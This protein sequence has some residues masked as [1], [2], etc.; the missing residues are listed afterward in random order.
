ME[1]L[2]KL[3]KLLTRREK[4]VGGLVTGLFCITSI[5][6]VVGLGFIFIY[7]KLILDPTELKSIPFLLWAQDFLSVNTRQ[8]LVILG[9][10]LLIVLAT[11]ALMALVCAWANFRFS[12]A[13]MASFSSDL[14]QIYLSK[15]YTYFLNH[16]STTLKQNILDEIYNAT[17]NVLIPVLYIVSE[18]LALSCIVLL[19]LFLHPIETLIMFAF[20][21]LLFGGYLLAVKKRLDVLGA[22]KNMTNHARHRLVGDAFSTIKEVILWDAK[23]H[24]LDKFRHSLKGYSYAMAWSHI[25]LQ[26]PRYLIEAVGFCL[27]VGLMMYQLLHSQDP[28]DIISMIALYGAAGMRM[29]P[30]FNRIATNAAQIRFHKRALYSFYN[31]LFLRRS[32]QPIKTLRSLEKTLS[33]NKTITYD[34]VSFAYAKGGN[35]IIS[36]LSLVIHKRSS[37]AFVGSSGAGKSTLIDLLLGLIYPDNGNIRIDDVTLDPF[38]ITAWRKQVGYVPQRV[39]LLDES[40]AANVAFGVPVSERNMEQV[41]WACKV[42]KIDLFIEQNLEHGYQTKLGENG[43][44]LSGGQAQRIAI[45]RALYH[46]PSVLILDEATAALDGVTEHEIVETMEELAGRMTL[47]MVAHRLNTVKNCDIIYLLENGQISDWGTYNALLERN[48]HFQKM[49][50]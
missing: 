44:R 32:L 28:A 38:N 31:D 30:S 42:A 46:K 35:N 25:L 39:V 50:G 19:L 5:L 29:M 6:E 47:I 48:E 9:A 12:L 21:G 14:F 7:V 40:V 34:Q 36:D 33:F 10:L 8:F 45:A 41:E 20:T 11:K 24:F 18:T 15:N 23:E 26:V 4:I 49:A 22:Q 3:Y 17:F 2:Y 27:I 16:N 43:I 1:L 37:I 13:R